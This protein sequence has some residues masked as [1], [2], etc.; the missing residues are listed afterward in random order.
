MLEVIDDRGHLP[1]FSRNDGA[2]GDEG[3]VDVIGKVIDD[4]VASAWAH[5][6]ITAFDIGNG[7]S[8]FGFLDGALDDILWALLTVFFDRG[9]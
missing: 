5:E 9:T 1:A 8:A 2:D 3:A 6:V 7:V 4:K